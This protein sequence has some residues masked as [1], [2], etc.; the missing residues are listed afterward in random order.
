MASPRVI[1]VTAASGHIGENLIPLLAAKSTTK[2]IL[3]TS[4]AAALNS[5]IA[6][7]AVPYPENITVVEGSIK[8][9]AWFQELLK[10][11][12]VDTVFLCLTGEDELWTTFNCYDA[13]SRVPSVKKLIYLSAQLDFTSTEGMQQVL[14]HQSAA[15]VVV[16]ILAEQKL[17]HGN[18]PFAWTVLR[19][20]LF[21]I[22]DVRCK[23][24][25]LEHGV[26]HE[27]LGEKGASRV[28]PWD[29]ALAVQRLVADDTAK[30]Q[31]KHVAIG[32]LKL[33]KGSEIAQIWSRALSREVKMHPADEQGLQQYEDEFL[34]RVGDARGA[35][36][37]R[38]L[39]LM[40]QAFAETGFGMNEDEYRE[41]VDLL[42]REPASYEDWVK[43]T[44][45]SWL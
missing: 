35:A 22:N 34:S 45:R 3:P 19:P 17:L 29:I 10:T 8:N 7:F 13:M 5:Q 26:F 20:T 40:Y 2:L 16:K 44:A 12:S 6:T 14:R 32:S 18:L 36:W 31:G 21:F 41:Q 27:P 39:R 28:A 24:G 25:M 37:G 23:Q 42:G 30:W 43:E 38:D 11:H 9:P 15:H 1:L 4:N 33:Y